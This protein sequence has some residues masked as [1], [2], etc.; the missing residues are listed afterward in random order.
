MSTRPTSVP[1][2]DQRPTAAATDISIASSSPRPLDVRWAVNVAQATV[3]PSGHG[4]E[5]EL[6]HQMI[7]L[8]LEFE[9]EE[10]MAA[11]TPAQ[12]EAVFDL[13]L[14][15]EHDRNTGLS[16]QGQFERR[17]GRHRGHC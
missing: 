14:W 10:I 16:L 3:E 8:H 4:P 7:A 13:D 6:A 12:L 17:T 11:A 5:L 1:S 15:G 9:N 2:N